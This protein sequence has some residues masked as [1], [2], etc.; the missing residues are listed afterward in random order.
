VTRPSNRCWREFTFVGADELALFARDCGAADSKLTPLLCLPG[1]TRNSSDFEPLAEAL[2]EPRRIVALD[3]RGRGRSQ[4]APDPAT[5]TPR[6]ELEDAM[7]LLDH[8]KLDRV[9][10]V[11]T[12]RGGIIAMLMAALHP[13]RMAGAVLNDIGPALEPAGLL[14]IVDLLHRHAGAAS[15][16]DAVASLKVS[17]PGIKNLKEE[18]WLAFAERIFAQE[19]K[20]LI[21]AYD[22]KI[23]QMFPAPEDITS[24]RVAELWDLFAALKA[25]PAAVLR[26]E[27]SDLLS[28]ATVDL[29]ALEHP[30]LMAVRVKDRGHVP[31]LNEPE[32][33]AAVSAIAAACD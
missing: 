30:D 6:H 10:V 5:Y 28:E 24:G 13:H 25:K 16:A 21:P 17:N 15:W 23:V 12:S 7:A 26:G 32:S 11:G 8:L 19:G 31:F 9:C 27:N 18:E 3:Y 14:R 29:M 2:N 1:L 22:P 20:W 33:V 4:Y